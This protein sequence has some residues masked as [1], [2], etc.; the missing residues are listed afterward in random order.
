MVVFK[1][2]E[3]DPEV[4]IFLDFPYAEYDLKAAFEEVPFGENLRTL[5]GILFL[6]PTD[7]GELPKLR[8]DGVDVDHGIA[9]SLLVVFI[10][11]VIEYDD[12]VGPQP[13]LEVVLI[14]LIDR[15]HEWH[16]V[17]EWDSTDFMVM[18]IRHTQIELI[19]A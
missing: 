2:I 9:G 11:F 19:L 3:E 18:L 17:A 14:E 13:V 7:D 4:G 5:E 15:N 8:E 6:N 16:V 1:D 12:G 10:E